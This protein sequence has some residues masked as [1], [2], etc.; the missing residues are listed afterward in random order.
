MK[1]IVF[2][3][4]LVLILTGG[5]FAQSFD[6]FSFDIG[7]TTYM[8]SDGG[9][10]INS[11]NNFTLN[12]RIDDPLVIGLYKPGTGTGI[13]VKY[14]FLPQL[15]GIVGYGAAGIITGTWATLGFDYTPF[16][17]KQGLATAF[18]L[19]VKYFG[20]IA[21]FFGTTPANSIIAFDLGLSIGY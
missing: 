13:L 9:G 5:A 21:D 3:S 6:I 17:Q 7:L 10:N 12:F 8:R 19:G 14:R 16:A 18:K 20:A 15:E 4:L 11:L 2:V 1:K